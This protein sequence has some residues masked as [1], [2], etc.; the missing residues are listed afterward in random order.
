M[1]APAP[2]TARPALRL[3]HSSLRP[4]EPGKEWR[5]IASAIVASTADVCRHLHQQ[6]WSRV[7]EELGER[8]ELLGLLRTLPLDPDGHSCLR[9]LEQAVRES[10]SAIAVMVGKTS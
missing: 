10:E 9:A 1:N 7:Q 8:R 3:I 5:R 4:R 6:R 2:G